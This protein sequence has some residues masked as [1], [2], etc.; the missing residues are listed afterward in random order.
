MCLEVTAANLFGYFL[1]R[2]PKTVVVFQEP[3]DVFSMKVRPISVRIT[4]TSSEPAFPIN[5]AP[6]SPTESNRNSLPK[7]S[8]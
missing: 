2:N 3:A 1:T 7:P 6:F 4:L 5:L 8:L